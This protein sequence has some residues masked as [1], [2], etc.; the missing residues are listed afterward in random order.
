MLSRSFLV[1][2]KFSYENRS[3]FQRVV[4]TAFEC[5]R[6]TIH[7]VS[8]IVEVKF[9]PTSVP[10]IGYSNVK[11]TCPSNVCFETASQ[12]IWLNMSML[13]F[14]PSLKPSASSSICF[15]VDQPCDDESELREMEKE[16]VEWVSAK[17]SSF[18][19]DSILHPSDSFS[20]SAEIYSNDSRRFAAVRQKPAGWRSGS[21]HGRRR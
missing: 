5:A 18:S 13:T 17:R 19:V 1:S 6:N 14:F 16:H 12:R 7:N 9:A 21:G 8:V 10:S 15:D 2:L 3:D 4:Q 11:Q 20:F